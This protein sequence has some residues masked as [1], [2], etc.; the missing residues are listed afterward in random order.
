M[1]LLRPE[2]LMT[3]R[4]VGC[5]RLRPTLR[6]FG[7]YKLAAAVLPQRRSLQLQVAWHWA[8]TGGNITAIPNTEGVKNFSHTASE[9]RTISVPPDMFIR[10]T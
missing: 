5:R 4:Y 6:P 8:V 2:V 9:R 10:Y 1:R 7:Q 3:A